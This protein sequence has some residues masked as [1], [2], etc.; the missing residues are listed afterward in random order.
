MV[1]LPLLL[2]AL[3]CGACVPRSLGGAPVL[4]L[5]IRF[6]LLSSPT[7]TALST[8][9]TDE[10]VVELVRVANSVWRQAGIEWYVE[11]VIREESLRGLAFDSLLSGAV[12][13]TERSL[14]AFVPRGQLLVPGWNVFLRS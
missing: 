13:R 1:R 8:T 4:R 2:I 7:S 12:P 3:L 5:P 6:H 11:S 10:D 14:T 9:R